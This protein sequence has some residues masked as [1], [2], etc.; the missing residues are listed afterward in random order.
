MAR[1]VA[2]VN[3]KGGVGKTT[4]AV[5]LAASVA[6]LK[7][8]VLLVDLD[9][10]AN[11]SSGFG[12]GAQPL[13][14]SVYAALVGTETV[15]KLTRET[16]MPTLS[17]LPSGSD[18]Y[19]VDLEIAAEDN[20]FY[21]LKD[22]L[23]P[24]LKNY[25]F[26]FIDCPPSL[27]LLTLNA[28]GAAHA[29]VIPMQCEYYALEGL[30]QLAQ[31]IDRVR[32]GINTHIDVDGVLFTM[33]DKRNNLTHQVAEEVRR[34]FGDKVFKSVVPRNVRLSEAPSFG[35][36]VLLYDAGSVGCQSY[37]QLAKEFLGKVEIPNKKAAA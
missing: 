28:L 22:A 14:L 32:G 5:N 34:Y 23:K 6:S 31:T 36:P 17:L 9:P 10:Q 3:Q 8:R 12:V 35:K 33:F 30:S 24:V 13:D 4:T 26:I 7:K 25:D 11:A 15:E 18:L 2:V 16:E 37:L 29:V 19:G 20:R 27:G 1:I 21:R